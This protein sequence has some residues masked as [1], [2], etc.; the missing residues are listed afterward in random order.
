M[1]KQMLGGGFTLLGT[2]IGLKRL[3]YGA[4]PAPGFAGTA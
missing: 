4:M 2:S 1:T 3:G